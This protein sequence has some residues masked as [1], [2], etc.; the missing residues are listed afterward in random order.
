[1]QTQYY[2]YLAKIISLLLTLSWRATY[3]IIDSED[4]LSSFGCGDKCLFFNSEAF[5]YARVTM[6][7][8]LPA[9]MLIPADVLP[10]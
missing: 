9:N 2:S 4:H 7:S 6:L 1:V 3:N 5:C 10:L 8:T